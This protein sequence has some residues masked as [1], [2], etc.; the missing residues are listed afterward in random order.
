M[1]TVAGDQAEVPE[2][3]SGDAPE[4]PAQKTPGRGRV[5]I[6]LQHQPERPQRQ[7]RRD[8]AI[9]QCGVSVDLTLQAIRQERVELD[10]CA[11][12]DLQ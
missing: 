10:S 1:T 5:G 3:G 12:H 7:P 8:V 9:V 6:P 4:T 2:A 11:H